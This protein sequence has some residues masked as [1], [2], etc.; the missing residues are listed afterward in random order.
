[1]LILNQRKSIILK[2]QEMFQIGLHL[3]KYAFNGSVKFHWVCVVSWEQNNINL[4][5]NKK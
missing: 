5:Q 2:F 3:L 1:M 4:Y